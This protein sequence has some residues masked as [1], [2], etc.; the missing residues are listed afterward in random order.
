MS[1]ENEGRVY[2]ALALLTVELGL[3]V[4]TVVLEMGLVNAVDMLELLVEIAIPVDEVLVEERLL[5]E[6][7]TSLAPSTPP[8]AIAT[9]TLFFM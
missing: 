1:S 5:D 7:T 3:E 8:P 9:P 6:L 4:R 2:V